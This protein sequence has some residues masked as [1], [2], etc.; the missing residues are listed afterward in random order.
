MTTETFS[1][2]Q[3]TNDA[4]ARFIAAARE[5]VPMLRDESLAIEAKRELTPRV[6]EALIERDLFRVLLAPVR[7]LGSVTTTQVAHIL[8]TLAEG[9][10]STAW[11]VMASMGGNLV[12]SFL[13]QHTV[14]CIFATASDAAATA[15]GRIG[16]AVAVDGGFLVDAR[17]PFL[18]GS[19]HATW[20]G[21]LC[22]VHDGDEPRLSPEHGPH[23]VMPFLRKERVRM[24][25]TWDA[26]GLRGTGSHEA[27]VNGAF[28]PFDETVDF[29]AGPRSG[30]P[31]LLRIEEDAVAPAV[32]ASIALGAVA[33]AIET[34]RAA[35]QRRAHASGVMG[36]EA[37]LPRL[38]LGEAEARLAQ[39]RAGLYAIL[40]EV[41]SLLAGGTLPGHEHVVRV[42][43]SATVAVESAID[44]ITK[45][46]RAAGAG[47]VF[48]G[49]PIERTLRD[50][51]ALGAHRM[52]QRENY[53]VHAAWIFDAGSHE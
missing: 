35:Q 50:V 39:A 34:F 4:G 51:F 7:G 42:T 26:L 30:L 10:A 44:I 16:K 32:A 48:S 18:S 6:L 8:E 14:D 24:L 25:D 40:A 45:L 19:P 43:L 13:P 29:A 21:G 31:L 12:S 23:I 27:E 2:P 33:G 15:V 49:S 22:M 5:M 52:V 20:V 17:W 9:D 38:A 46:F 11:D 28:V 3:T 36:S 47:A 41:D 53:M 37:P 1:N